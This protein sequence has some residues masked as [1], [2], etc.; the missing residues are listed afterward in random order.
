MAWN[1]IATFW[2]SA[3]TAVAVNRPAINAIWERVISPHFIHETAISCFCRAANCR[4][5]DPFSIM[6]AI[7]ELNVDLPRIVEVK[8]S[9]GEAVIE[10]HAAMATFNAVN[11][12]LY[13]SPSPKLFPATVKG[14]V[15]RQ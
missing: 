14:G 8:P 6:K 15:V 10:Q 3:N 12:T 4:T 2:S 1:R 5:L 13:F 7:A 9:E 11:D